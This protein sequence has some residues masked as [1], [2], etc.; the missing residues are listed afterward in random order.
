MILRSANPKDARVLGVYTY[1][2]TQL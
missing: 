2:L 1:L